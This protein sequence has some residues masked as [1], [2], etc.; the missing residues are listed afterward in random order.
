M[1]KGSCGDVAQRARIAAPKKAKTEAKKRMQIKSESIYAD[2]VV[3][4]YRGGGGRQY[5]PQAA[6]QRWPA[7]SRGESAAQG[8]Q[9]TKGNRAETKAKQK[10]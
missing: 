6:R 7:G 5:Q 9:R 2:R 10:Q 8:T 1:T 4:L 3:E